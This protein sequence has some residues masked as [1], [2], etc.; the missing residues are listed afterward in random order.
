MH[1]PIKTDQ[2]NVL[3]FPQ[4]NKQIFANKQIPF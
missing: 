3:S 4:P 2:I 1:K